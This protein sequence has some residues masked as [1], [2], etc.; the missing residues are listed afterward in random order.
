VFAINESISTIIAKDD[1]IKSTDLGASNTFTEVYFWLPFFLF[2]PLAYK[3]FFKLF[4]TVG[5]LRFESILRMQ[6]L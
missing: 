1:R 5:H 4:I 6:P 3:L 2:H